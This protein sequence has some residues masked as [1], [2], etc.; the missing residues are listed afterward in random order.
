[1]ALPAGGV[2]PRPPRGEPVIKV[3]V[4]AALCQG[5]TLCHLQD[6]DLFTLDDNGYSDVGVR[7]VPPGSEH[8][9]RRGAD[10]CPERAVTLD[11]NDEGNPW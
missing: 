3:L 2:H 7:Q 4:S 11:E 5:H 6:P 9:A 10:V 8:R 1:M